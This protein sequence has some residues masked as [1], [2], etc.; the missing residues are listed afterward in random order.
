M[1]S[2]IVIP[3]AVFLVMLTWGCATLLKGST[4][5]VQINSQP[6]SAKVTVKTSTGIVVTQGVT[7]L[8]ATL[9]K[10]NEYQVTIELAGYAPQTVGI[11]KGGIESV[12]FCNLFV[13]LPWLIDW[14][15]GSMYKLEP[16]T[17]NVQLLQARGEGNDQYYA[18]VHYRND[19][20]ELGIASLPLVKL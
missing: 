9:S 19:E 7:P 18:V 2:R 3:S 15:T 20:G 13:P 5:S 17:I 6:P 4:S 14:A 10:K 16:N 8:A 1:K 12:A 11:M